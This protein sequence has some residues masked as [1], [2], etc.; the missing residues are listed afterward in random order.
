MVVDTITLQAASMVE[1]FV[2]YIVGFIILLG[3][4]TLGLQ[5]LN[6]ASRNMSSSNAGISDKIA[7]MFNRRDGQGS[8]TPKKE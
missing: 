5:F 7:G 3:M 4:G 2:M 1:N 8:N 6:Q